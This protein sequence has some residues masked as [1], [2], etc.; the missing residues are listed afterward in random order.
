MNCK[1]YNEKYGPL[2]EER[3][4]DFWAAI[5]D[6]LEK[7]PD[8]FIS[9][10]T[11]IPGFNDGEP[12]LPCIEFI[13][14]APGFV[15]DYYIDSRGESHYGCDLSYLEEIAFLPKEDREYLKDKKDWSY[16]EILLNKPAGDLELEAVLMNG[17]EDFVQE[18]N[19]T[20]TIKLVNDRRRKNHGE[21][22]VETEHYECY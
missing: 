18:W 2:W 6:W 16:S 1:E 3:K 7:N 15:D 12:C 13:G 20:G 17:Y 10:R 11:Y 8:R 4:R 19:V 21:P 9:F 22:V 14:P 5:K